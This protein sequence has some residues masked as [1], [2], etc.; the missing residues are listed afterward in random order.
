MQKKTIRKITLS[1]ETLIQLDKTQLE[2]AMGGYPITS[3][4]DES[5]CFVC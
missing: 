2:Q 4:T 5:R 1:R 3:P